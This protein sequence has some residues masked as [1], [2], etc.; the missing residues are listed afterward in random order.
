MPI[1][2]DYLYFAKSFE[3]KHSHQKQLRNSINKLRF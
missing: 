1:H 2:W 3:N